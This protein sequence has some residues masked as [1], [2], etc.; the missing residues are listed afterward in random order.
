MVASRCIRCCFPSRLR[1][2]EE[3]GWIGLLADAAGYKLAKT[4]KGQA[5]AT[6]APALTKE[7]MRVAT[8]KLTLDAECK[9]ID[10][11]V[12]VEAYGSKTQDDCEF[13]ATFFIS[14][15]SKKKSLTGV[16]DLQA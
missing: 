6:L 10:S 1:V 2:L 7:A 9:L 16:I 3:E 13:R 8:L 5:Y 11:A 14:F 12:A 15:V 4:T